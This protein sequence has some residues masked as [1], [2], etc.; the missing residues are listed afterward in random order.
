MRLLKRIELVP[1]RRHPTM[2]YFMPSQESVMNPIEKKKN[3]EISPKLKVVDLLQEHPFLEETLVSLSAHFRML[4][5]P[6]MRKTV[7]RF[8][9]LDDAA[10]MSKIPINDLITKLQTAIQIHDPMQAAQANS[11]QKQQEETLKKIIRD[12]HNGATVD[13]AK[14]RFKVLAKEVDASQI[15]VLEQSLISEGMPPEE[16]ARLCD[17]HAEVFKEGLSNAGPLQV[18]DDH[19]IYNYLRENREAE[20]ICRNI[21]SLLNVIGL[22]SEKML[23]EKRRL[24]LL[25]MLKNLSHINLHY[26]RKENQVFPFLEKHKITGPSK[27]MWM[28]HDEIR[29]QMKACII[30][31]E[32]GTGLE[33]LAKV[34]TLLR[35]ILDMIYKE[36]HILFP[37]CQDVFSDEDW[38]GVK[39]GENEIALAWFAPTEN[40]S[41]SPSSFEAPMG[42]LPL[43]TGALTLEQIRLI[44]SNLPVDLSFVDE[45]DEVQFYS[46]GPERIFPR[47]PGVI[48]R[49]VK[50]CHPPK[51]LHAVEEILREFRAGRKSISEFWI[52]IQSKFL[53]IRYFA[54]RDA[55]GTYKGCLEVSQDVTHIRSLQGERRL[56]DW[57]S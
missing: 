46:A 17:L 54:I 12:L 55:Q 43:D 4:K 16:I 22:S 20:R 48:G 21:S 37:M 26:T 44:F 38:R 8:A 5:N 32:S 23:F 56:L 24:D 1:S 10:G 6:I 35:S 33:N 15:A 53:H 49:N 50:N 39:K 13:E 9:T 25:L 11:G 40:F 42:T 3:T 36:E 18:K 47:S 51:S 7:G 57:N 30:T 31:V 19:P 41:L 28:V 34:Q 14:H 27:V 2:D 29:Q 52:T 45:N